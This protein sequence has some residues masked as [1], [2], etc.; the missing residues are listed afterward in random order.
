[1]DIQNASNPRPNELKSFV[2]DS[3]PMPWWNLKYKTRWLSDGSLISGNPILTNFLWNE[4]GRGTDLLELENWMDQSQTKIKYL[5]AAIFATKA[6]HWTDFFPTHSI[7]LT[8]AKRGET[9]FQNTCQSCHGVYQKGW[10]LP[11]ADQLNIKDKLKTF[12][13]TY[14]SKTPVINV[15]TDPNR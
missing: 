8:S 14:H 5:T 7:N 15:G 13:V 6:P 1:M 11:N 9:I 3:K 12:K 10:G 4:L 2:A